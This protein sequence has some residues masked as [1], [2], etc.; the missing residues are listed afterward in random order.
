MGKVLRRV[1]VG[2]VRVMPKET[3]PEAIGYYE[4]ELAKTAQEA[5]EEATPEVYS[6]EEIAGMKVFEVFAQQVP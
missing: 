2:F 6:P 4:G 5:R 3:V 1:S